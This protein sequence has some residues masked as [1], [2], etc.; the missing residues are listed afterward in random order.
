MSVLTKNIDHQVIKFGGK[1][2]FAVV[3]FEQFEKMA[4]QYIPDES[5][6]S[7]PHEVIKANFN[8]DSLL[9]AWREHLGLTQVQLASRLGI[10]QPAMAK[11]ERPAANLRK[12]TLK[13]L[14]QAL[15]LVVEQLED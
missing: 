2:A 4:E 3:P 1:P 10:S 11:L 8:G 5:N 9:K 7:F 6:V 15:G 14:A 13:K 12:S